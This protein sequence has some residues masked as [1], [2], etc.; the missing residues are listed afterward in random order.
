LPHLFSCKPAATGEPFQT[1]KITG[2]EKLANM[3]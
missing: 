1:F 2:H 3:A